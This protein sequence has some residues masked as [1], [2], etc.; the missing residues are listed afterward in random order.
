MTSTTKKGMCKLLPT[1]KRGAGT[2][3]TEVKLHC[4][5]TEYGIAKFYGKS[6]KGRAR[7]LI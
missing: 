1:S 3:P 7:L 4:R 6:L 5:V 2:V